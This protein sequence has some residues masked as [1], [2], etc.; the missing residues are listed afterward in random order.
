MRIIPVGYANPRHRELI[1]QMM[2]K[3]STILVDARFSPRSA[4]PG[5]HKTSLEN[6]YPEQY[7]DLGED[8]LGNVNYNNGGPI[9]IANLEGGILDLITVLLQGFTVLLLCGCSSYEPTTKHPQGCHRKAICEALVRE[10]SGVE[11][12]QPEALVSRELTLQKLRDEREALY[13]ELNGVKPTMAN[14]WSLD[15]AQKDL[16]K[17]GVGKR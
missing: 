8:L 9:K 1:A 16:V 11:I 17:Q 7:I 4:I 6:K 14:Y 10:W 13:L 5:W 15:V 3:S 2:Q 12:V